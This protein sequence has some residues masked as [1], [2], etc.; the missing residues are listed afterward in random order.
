MEIKRSTRKRGTQDFPFQL[1]HF[2]PRRTMPET[3]ALLWHPEIELLFATGDALIELNLSGR[4]HHL[5]GGDIYILS[6]DELHCV[7]TLRAGGEY[8]SC[9]ITP[10]L[11][12]LPSTHFFQQ[13]FLQPLLA[14]KKLLPLTLEKDMPAYRSVAQQL[15]ILTHLDPDAPDYKPSVFLSVLTICTI[16]MPLCTAVDP[17]DRQ[18][19]T[20]DKIRKCMYYMQENL[21]RKLTL[22]EIAA[23]VHLHPNYLCKLFKACTGQSVFGCLTQLRISKA[24]ELLRDNSLSVAQAGELSGF[25]SMEFFS[26]KFKLATGLTPSAYRKQP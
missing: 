22:E 12:D 15:E 2:T 8:W 16:L 5:K 17:H 9:V 10:E 13:E 21:Q 6:P 24:K 3:A 26:R 23:H 25:H 11:F 14:K 4:S 1:Q 7:R 20:N 18:Q 19:K